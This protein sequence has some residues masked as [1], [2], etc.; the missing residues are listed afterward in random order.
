MRYAKLPIAVTIV[1][2]VNVVSWNILSGDGPFSRYVV[3][4]IANQTDREAELKFS[5]AS[6][7]VMVR[8]KD[9]CR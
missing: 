9:S 6:C 2:A 4:E 5:S 8:P 3:L 1:P 7:T